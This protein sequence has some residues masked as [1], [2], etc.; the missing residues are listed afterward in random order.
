M[1]IWIDAHISPGIAAWLNETYSHEA[2]SRFGE[3]ETI[4]EIQ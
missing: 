3:G 4:V 2:L 1:R